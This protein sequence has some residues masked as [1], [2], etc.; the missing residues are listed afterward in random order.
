MPRDFVG[1]V[2]RKNLKRLDLCIDKGARQRFLEY[3][4]TLNAMHARPRWY[5]VL[6]TNCTTSIRTQHAVTQRQ[7]WDWRILLNGLGDEM[8]YEHGALAGGLPFAQLK[9]RAHINEA[10]RAANDAPD[11]SEG[12]RAGRPAFAP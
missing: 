2:P 6:T 12:I 7:P 11:F 1:R 10:A 5:N 8:L 9:E 3:L 4:A